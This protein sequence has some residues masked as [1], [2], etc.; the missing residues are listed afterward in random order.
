MYKAIYKLLPIMFQNFF[1]RRDEEHDHYTR[2]PGTLQEPITEDFP[3]FER[4]DHLE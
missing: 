4:A 2:A 3:Y 1:V